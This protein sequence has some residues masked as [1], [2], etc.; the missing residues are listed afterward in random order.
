MPGDKI[1]RWGSSKNAKVVRKF[2]TFDRESLGMCR[3]N[4]ERNVITVSQVS[5]CHM[6]TSQQAGVIRALTLLCWKMLSCHEH[7][8]LD[9]STS[10]GSSEVQLDSDVNDSLP[11]ATATM[12][13]SQLAPPRCSLKVKSHT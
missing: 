11:F 10:A 6:E 2:V 3:K 7:H 9:F 5:I 8:S 12:E 4:S 13:I 1:N